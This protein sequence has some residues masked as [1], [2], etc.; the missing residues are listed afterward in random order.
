MQSTALEQKRVDLQS[1]LPTLCN[2]WLLLVIIVKCIFCAILGNKKG[3][4][5]WT[6]HQ[7]SPTS[8]ST[9]DTLFF[10][11]L[12][13]SWFH[14]SWVYTKIWSTGLSINCWESVN[15]HWILVNSCQTVFCNFIRGASL[16]NFLVIDIIIIIII[17]IITP[18]HQQNWSE[19]INSYYY[20]YYYYYVLFL[21]SMNRSSFSP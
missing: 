2:L 14:V 21:F 20:Y 6:H 12:A 9:T 4:G 16:H 8:Q 7:L 3:K 10:T 1:L 11:C 18:T 13:F 15:Q 17:I 5:C 19:K